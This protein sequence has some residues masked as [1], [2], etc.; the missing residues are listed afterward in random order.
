MREFKNKEV[1]MGLIVIIILAIIAIFL[2][3]R[4][5]VK[6]ANESETVTAEE[7]QLNTDEEVLDDSI[8][9]EVTVEEVDT[10]DEIKNVTDEIAEAETDEEKAVLV[11]NAIVVDKDESTTVISEDVAT[12]LGKLDHVYEEKTLIERKVRDSQLEELYTYWNDYKLEAVD[13]LVHLERVMSISEELEGT[14]NYYYYGET[15]SAGE[16]NGSGL[17]VYANNA[18]YCGD[19]VD[20]QRSGNGMWLQEYIYDDNIPAEDQMIIEHSYNGEWSNDLPN[21]EGQ[22]HYSYNLDALEDGIR[23]INNVIGTFADGYYTGEEYI[24]T[25]EDNGNINNFMGIA[26]RGVW[27][28]VEDMNELGEIPIWYRLDVENAYYWIM[29]EENYN[30]GIMGLKKLN[31]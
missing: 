29:P 2:I 15:N 16:P 23:Y 5:E 8:D 7:V 14:H 17:A 25:I 28:L 12:M 19:W 21:G 18:Y 11:T 26:I 30:Y 24:M 9:M 10:S 27:S 3:F 13:D 20:G 22:E 31:D 4:R 1:I 6:L